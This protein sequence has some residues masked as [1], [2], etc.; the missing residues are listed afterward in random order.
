MC[1]RFIVLYALELVGKVVGR[2]LY[3]LRLYKVF[4]LSGIVVFVGECRVFRFLR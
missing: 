1:V 3:G 4:R 2:G